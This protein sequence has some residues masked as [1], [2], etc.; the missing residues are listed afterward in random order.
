MRGIARTAALAVSFL[1]IYS[2]RFFHGKPGA[3]IWEQK[4][5]KRLH[6]LLWQKNFLNGF[7]IRFYGKI[8]NRKDFTSFRFFSITRVLRP[9]SPVPLQ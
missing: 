8:K 2:P 1:C 5:T 9:T 6:A 3:N 4:V 7:S